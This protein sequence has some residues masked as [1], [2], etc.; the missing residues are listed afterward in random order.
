[1][2]NKTIKHDLGNSMVIIKH[3]AQ[4]ADPIIDRIAGYCLEHKISITT[5]K[6]FEIL[7][8]AMKIIAN[9]CEK[10]ATLHDEI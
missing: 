7:K 2:T 1:M 10:L 5:P 8:K 3:M 9:E 4:T 6:Q